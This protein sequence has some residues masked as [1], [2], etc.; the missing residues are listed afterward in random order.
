[1][2]P[3]EGQVLVRLLQLGQSS[4]HLLLLQQ[5]LVHPVPHALLAE[6]KVDVTPPPSISLRHYIN[7]INCA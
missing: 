4:G 7:M 5:G 3:L 2:L 6:G 1:M